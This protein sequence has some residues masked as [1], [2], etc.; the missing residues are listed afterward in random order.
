ME[1]QASIADTQI[2]TSEWCGM[3]MKKKVSVKQHLLLVHGPLHKA[4]PNMAA[5]FNHGNEQ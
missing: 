3:E 2:V 4:A 5:L 1:A